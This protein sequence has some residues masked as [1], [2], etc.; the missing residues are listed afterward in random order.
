MVPLV[1]CFIRQL[2]AYSTLWDA[3]YICIDLL[4]RCGTIQI[5]K[6]FPGNSPRYLC[7][8]ATGEWLAGVWGLRWNVA[9]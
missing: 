2:Y 9:A 5:F 8:R 3:V 4:N 1:S 6:G 7:Y